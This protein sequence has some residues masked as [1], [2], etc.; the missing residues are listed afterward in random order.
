MQRFFQDFQ[1]YNSGRWSLRGFF[2]ICHRQIQAKNGPLF[3]I[4]FGGDVAAQTSGRDQHRPAPIRGPCGL[5]HGLP[6]PGYSGEMGNRG[7]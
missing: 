6:T 3:G 5:C 7:T 1:K 2:F 4:T